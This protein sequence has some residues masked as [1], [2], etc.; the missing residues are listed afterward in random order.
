ML[1]H[2]RH[3]GDHPNGSDITTYQPTLGYG[4]KQWESKE[5]D[6]SSDQIDDVFR[7]IRCDSECYSVF[8]MIVWCDFLM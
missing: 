2:S 4:I 6:G 1:T 5:K 7:I 8:R 3:T